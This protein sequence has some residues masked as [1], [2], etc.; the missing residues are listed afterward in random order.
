MVVGQYISQKA[1]YEATPE[2][3]DKLVRNGLGFT[4]DELDYL[5]RPRDLPDHLYVVAEAIYQKT[6]DPL[7]IT[8]ANIATVGSIEWE[9]KKTHGNYGFK[10]SKLY[11]KEKESL[12][13][14]GLKVTNMHL[15]RKEI[16]AYFGNLE[17]TAPLWEVYPSPYDWLRSIKLF[18]SLK[19][20]HRESQLLGIV[21]A[22]ACL[23]NKHKGISNIVLSFGE[24]N[25]E[26]YDKLILPELKNIFNIKENI[27]ILGVEEAILNLY[28]TNIHFKAHDTYQV[29]IGSQAITQ[30]LKNINFPKERY[31]RKVGLP[32]FLPKNKVK[33]KEF[34]YEKKSF[35]EGIIAGMG[36]PS[37]DA[38][39]IK[40]EDKDAT[41]VK[42]IR[43]LALD[44]GLYCSKISEEEYHRF[45]DIGNSGKMKT[46]DLELI[47]PK[48][49]AQ[50]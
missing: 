39:T 44:L 33:R 20:D 34:S 7:S 14:K 2:Q 30:T 18:D 5:R 49:A 4:K 6:D 13:A 25:Y 46:S 36:S 41:F 22:D 26:F 28:G 35:L 11:K 9:G 24:S 50:R 45:M 17:E 3:R 47:N 31:K 40:I 32:K 38:K 10:I 15:L 1:L 23:Q 12:Q 43:K 16:G 42:N 19:L 29:H 48:H 8:T 27:N 21:W 37:N